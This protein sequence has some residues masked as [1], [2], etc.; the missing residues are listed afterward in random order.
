MFLEGFGEILA[1][2]LTVNP[3]L[4]GISSASSILD[5]S[6]YTFHA[7][8]F[9]KDAEGYNF[10]AHSVSDTGQIEGYNNDSVI[11]IN[12]VN[13]APYVSSYHPS[14]AH[15]EFSA[16]YNS[17]P[18][19]PAPNHTRLEM[20]PTRTTTAS[21]FAEIAPDLGHYPNTWIDSS[22]SNAWNILGGFSPPSSAGKEYF[23]T[24]SKGETLASGVLSGMYN[25]YGLVDK[26][27]YV[28]ISQVS[29]LD[30]TLGATQGAELS[31]GPVIYS[32][33]NFNAT[34]GSVGLAV[35]PQRG[36]AVTLAMYGGVN[37]I[38]VYC[39]DIRA[40]LASGI[41]PPYSWD[42]LNN[43][44]IYKLVSKVTFWDNLLDHEDNG[45]TPGLESAYNDSFLT[46]DGPT[47]TL[48]FNFL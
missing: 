48:K 17:V 20:G 25:Q 9:G 36:D 35:V 18:Q 38:G 37:H 1:N 10:H 7:V 13:S 12:Y 6:N 3:E 32:S 26:N 43:N 15:A 33:V 14:G 8:T 22:L 24:D 30:S 46:N 44:S 31:G 34:L 28:K 16:T 2:I 21:A 27:G 29:G 41:S 11:A 42:A 19:F 4:S 45:S 47:F 23:I 39:L 40:M 5:T